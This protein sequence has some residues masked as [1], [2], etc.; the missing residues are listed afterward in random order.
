MNKNLITRKRKKLK[1]AKKLY[2]EINF[3]LLNEQDFYNILSKN[4]SEII[5]KA[6]AS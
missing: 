5:Q 1:L 4:E 6:V 3:K 2:P